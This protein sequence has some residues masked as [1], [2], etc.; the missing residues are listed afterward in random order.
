VIMA[1]KRKG[2][3]KKLPFGGKK[4]PPF[5]KGGKKGGTKVKTTAGGVKTAK[6]FK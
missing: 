1:R 2:T 5:G 6:V 4:A 3:T